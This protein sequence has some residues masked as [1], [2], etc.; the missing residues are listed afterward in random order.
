[1]G[2]FQQLCQSYPEGKSRKF[3]WKTTIFLWFFGWEFIR[4]ENHEAFFTRAQ[5]RPF[6]RSTPASLP[7]KTWADIEVHLPHLPMVAYMCACVYICAIIYAY[8]YICIYIVYIIY[9]YIYGVYIYIC[10]YIHIY[11]IY[12]YICIYV[13]VVYIYIYITF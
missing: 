9:I 10:I 6:S 13:Y 1:M 7:H 2:H 12:V 4:Y 3:R 11:G 8:I 5:S